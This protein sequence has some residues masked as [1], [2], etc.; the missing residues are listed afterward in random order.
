M[1]E[2]YE[3]LR[4]EWLDTIKD[5]RARGWAVIIFAPDELEAADRDEFEE[6]LADMGCDLADLMQPD[7]PVLWEPDCPEELE[8]TNREDRL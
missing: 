2:A 4:P 8:H 5:M 6:R 7:E 3:V 1:A